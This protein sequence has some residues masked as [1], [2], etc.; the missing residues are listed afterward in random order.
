MLDGLWAL[1]NGNGGNGGNPNRVYFT[2]GINDEN[3]GLFGSLQIPEPGELPLFGGGLA[4]L[5]LLRWRRKAQI[6]P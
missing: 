6:R 2:A 4:T 1:I 3:D 5:G